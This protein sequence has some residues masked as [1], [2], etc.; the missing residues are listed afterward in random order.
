MVQLGLDSLINKLQLDNKYIFCMYVCMYVYMYVYMY[1][2][3]RMWICYVDIMHEQEAIEGTNLQSVAGRYEV[4]L[5]KRYDQ[6]AVGPPLE[7]INPLKSKK[8]SL[9]TIVYYCIYTYTFHMADILLNIFH[10]K[11]IRLTY[12][13]T[14]IHTCVINCPQEKG[15]EHIHNKHVCKYVSDLTVM[16]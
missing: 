6:Q 8:R 1:V 9:S 2:N 7:V 13:H 15:Y 10:N 12:I 14:Y 5:K 3:V 11:E 16:P 4:S